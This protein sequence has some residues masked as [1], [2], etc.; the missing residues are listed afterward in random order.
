MVRSILAP[1]LALVLLSVGSA[2]GTDAPGKMD[3]PVEWSYRDDMVGALAEYI[4]NL[5]KSQDRETGR[6]G[7]GIWIVQ[8]QHAMWPL[9]VAW[10][11]RD[12]A[13]PY[14]HD[15]ELLEAVMVAGDALIADADPNGM[16]MFRKKDA[17]TWGEIYMPWT[18][19]RWVR[20]FGIIKDAMPTARRARWE[21]A[22]TIGYKGIAEG[23]FYRVHNIPAYH[24]MSLYFAGEALNR[25]EW[26]EK[27]A[28][29]M[30]LVAAD[31]DINGYWSE[32]FGPV[33]GYNF[34]YME[35]L[36][37]YYGASCDQEVLY[38]LERGARYHANF[39]YPD[40][41]AVETV[42]ER[43]VYHERVVF[44]NVGFTFTPE[45]RGYLKAQ[46]ERLQD[47]GRRGSADGLAS[48]LW[49]GEEGTTLPTPGEKS[50][51][52]YVLGDNEA[53]VH[54]EGPWFVCLSTYHT[55]VPNNRWIQDRQNFVSLFHD[56]TG[57]ILGGGNTKL[58]PYW[59]TFCAGN[60][61]LLKHTPGDEQPN[62]VPPPGI[63]HIPEAATLD[64]DALKASFTYAGMGSSVDV[65]LVDAA[66]ARLV[67]TADPETLTMPL[68]ANVTLQPRKESEWSTASGGKGVLKEEAP[69]Q[70][71]SQEAGSW[72]GYNGYRISIPAGASIRWPVYGHN[73]YKKAGEGSFDFAR[74]VLTLP[75]TKDTPRHTVEVEIVGSEAE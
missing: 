51:H 5:L 20:S 45:G 13:N 38:A 64:P 25:P 33:V 57:L 62:F 43:H 22:L 14:F 36:G 65:D 73:P 56:R 54:R 67:F 28:E 59:S 50:S 29:F 16:W 72:I 37:C 32:N 10:G 60:P 68:I 39:T 12:Q 74:I 31:Q 40:G 53:M 19:S 11:L 27:A 69:F 30:R 8:D 21:E 41:S 70:F 2:A 35:A 47:E 63:A 26:T 55:E 17:S 3:T 49:Y 46:W 61:E 42:D 48:I 18:Y 4:P 71:T 75:L 24:A 58:Q 15:P 9:A 23:E 44:P 6:F 7:K 34:V 52:H 1:A 66:K